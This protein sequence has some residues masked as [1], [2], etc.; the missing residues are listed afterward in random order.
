MILFACPF[1]RVKMG[2]S[3]V[4]QF[5]ITDKIVESM[6]NAKALTFQ[7]PLSSGR[8][9]RL[10]MAQTGMDDALSSLK[11]KSKKK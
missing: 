2:L 11:A 6:K 10:K 8:V 9:M 1:T 7:Y 5:E 3:I 4:S